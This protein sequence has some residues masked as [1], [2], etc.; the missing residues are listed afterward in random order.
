MIFLKHVLTDN[1]PRW[2]NGKN[3][4]KINWKLSIGYTVKFVYKNIEGELIIVNY[5]NKY[6][7]IKYLDR[8]IYKITAGHFINCKLGKLIGKYTNE[9]KIEI[10]TKF[11]D[12]KRD[13]IVTD[14]QIKIITRK[15]GNNEKQKWYKYRCNKCGWTEGLI[16]EGAL[17]TS[18][19]GCSCCTGTTVVEGINSIVDTNPEMIKYFQGGYDEAKLYTKGSEKKIYP[20]CPD[21]GRV[22]TNKVIICNISKQGIGCSCGDGIS[23]PEKFIISLFEQIG[24]EF[25]SEYSP[26]WIKPRRYDFFFKVCD[27]NY[28][29]EMDGGFHSNDNNMNGQTKERSQE[30][31]NYK[32][33]MAEEHKIQVIRINSEVSELEYIKNSILKS[34][35]AELFDLHI[36]DWYKCEEFALSNL[37]KI[38]CNYKKHNP[39][40]G[41]KEIAYVMK[42]G[43]NTVTRYLKRGNKIGWCEYNP[44]EERKKGYIKLSNLAKNREL[45][46]NSKRVMCVNNGI[47]FKSIGECEKLSEEILGINIP[48]SSISRVCNEIQKQTKGYKFKYLE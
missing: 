44:E 42:L 10:G 9:F 7:H 34:K 5:D 14:K 47:I 30:I 18:K 31:D 37:V 39:D 25:K 15:D 4:G 33:R 8:P 6:L 46:Y 40:K 13:M 17:L 43:K 28:I 29:I 20:I 45:H 1:L 41:A 36:V 22:K 23:Y 48:R 19:Q 16:L 35:L 38:V 2:E 26:D 12:E 3:K 27:T 21:C 24:I 11:K 32:N